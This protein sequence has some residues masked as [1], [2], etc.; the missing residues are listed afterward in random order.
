MQLEFLYENRGT[1]NT[2]ELKPGVAFCLR[3]FYGLINELV[4]GAWVRF[5]RVQNPD[6]L[7]STTDL[8]DFMF[9]GE[10]FVIILVLTLAIPTMLGGSQQSRDVLALVGSRIYVSPTADEKLTRAQAQDDN[11]SRFFRRRR[12]SNEAN[13][14]SRFRATDR[15]RL[16]HD[17]QGA[18]AQTRRE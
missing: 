4:R 13:R 18:S 1:G 2:I 14:G 5:V 11:M 8:M 15:S 10:R 17:A 3:Q 12:G 16:R 6:L 7:G 9:G